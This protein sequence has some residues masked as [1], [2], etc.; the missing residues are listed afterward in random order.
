MFDTFLLQSFE[1]GDAE[2]AEKEAEEEA[3]EAEEE[4]AEPDAMEEAEAAGERGDSPP[5]ED[6]PTESRVNSEQWE[7]FCSK[8]RSDPC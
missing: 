3:E 4:E 5:K 2:A 1:D 6:P 8:A 7:D